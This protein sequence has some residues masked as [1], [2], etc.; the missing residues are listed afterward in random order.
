LQVSLDVLKFNVPLKDAIE[1]P[2][3]H[4]VSGYGPKD[5]PNHIDI[6]PAMPP[7]LEKA[8]TSLGWDV[9]RRQQHDFYFGSVN[10]ALIDNGTIFGVADQRRTSS[11]GGD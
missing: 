5:I 9:T 2:R 1:A 4:L 3:F 10:A 11:A 6:E 7:G 8:L